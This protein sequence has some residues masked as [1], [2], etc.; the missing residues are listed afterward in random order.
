MLL[1]LAVTLLSNVSIGDQRFEDVAM[2]A[3]ESLYNHRSPKGLVS[4][5]WHLQHHG[6]TEKE[7]GCLRM[8]A[9][10]CIRFTQ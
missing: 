3:L 10:C 2:K 6:P 1:L 8:R 7:I 4:I 9:N 5:S